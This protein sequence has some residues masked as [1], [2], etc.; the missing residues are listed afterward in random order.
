V[1]VEITEQE[2]GKA[3][4]VKKPIMR[5]G[6]KEGAVEILSIDVGNNEVRIR[7][8]TI[9]TNLVFEVAKS[10][11]GPGPGVLGGPAPLPT[12]P[13]PLGAGSPSTAPMIISPNGVNSAGR[14]NTGVSVYGGAANPAAPATGASYAAT[15]SAGFTLNSGA[16]NS[17]YGRPNTGLAANNA[18]IATFGAGVPTRELRTDPVAQNQQQKLDSYAGAQALKNFADQFNQSRNIPPL[19]VPQSRYH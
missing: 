10:A 3:P 6:D 15:A 1:L 19:P 5:R 16:Y 8:G 17:S 2:P 9:E 11:P 13:V 14:A 18:G 12:A 7:N 4:N